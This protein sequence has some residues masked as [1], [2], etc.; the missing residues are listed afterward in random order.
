MSLP[1]DETPQFEPQPQPTPK[2]PKRSWI[3]RFPATFGLIALTVVFFA[4]QWLSQ[5]ILGADLVLY[6]GVKLRA[7]VKAGE[8]W[9]LITPIF[10]HIGILHFMVNM[11]SLFVLG[12]AV[13]SLFGSQ[14]MPLFYLISGIGGV[15]FSMLFSASLSA[16][17]SGAIF[18]LLGALVAFLYAHRRILGQRGLMQFR[19]LIL[20]AL[21]NLFMSLTPGID[22]WGHVGGLI[23]GA[24]ITFLLGPVMEPIWIT[25][26][27]PQ[28]VDRRPWREIWQRTLMIG[29]IVAGLALMASFSTLGA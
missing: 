3:R 16:G 19:H 23:T 2:V 21:L 4:L 17:A 28:L 6:Y 13:E 26:E 18:G 7:A 11:Y 25:P 14:R 12:P 15:A 10:I 1:P 22:G 20:I 9:R 24:A 29:A 8:I 5:L 27:R